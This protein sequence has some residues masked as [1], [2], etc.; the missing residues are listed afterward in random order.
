VS[1]EEAQR[2]SDDPDAVD[3]EQ[4]RDRDP[5]EHQ[6]RGSDADGSMSFPGEDAPEVIGAGPPDAD[7]DLDPEADTPDAAGRIAE[8]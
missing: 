4:Q 2:G 8:P 5:D 3:L 7:R 6:R 1:I